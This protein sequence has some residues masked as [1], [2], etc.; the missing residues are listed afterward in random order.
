MRFN[1]YP[2]QIYCTKY[3]N[4]FVILFR[5][6]H[7][8]GYD[9]NTIHLYYLNYVVYLAQ[10]VQIRLRRRFTRKAITKC[11][12]G[13]IICLL[14]YSCRD[15]QLMEEVESN[16]WTQLSN[17]QFSYNICTVL[18]EERH[19][20]FITDVKSSKGILP[21]A[22]TA[23]PN[24]DKLTQQQQCHLPQGNYGSWNN[25]LVT[26]LLPG[27]APKM[28]NKLFTGQTLSAKEEEWIDES[29]HLW[30]SR[31][32]I[33]HLVSM[34]KNCTWIKST[35]KNNFFVSDA[36][37]QF[38][39]AYAINVDRYPHQVLRFL[40]VIY[41]PHNLYCLHFDLKSSHTFKRIIF[42][43]A[44]CLENVIVPRKIEDVYRGWHT[45]IDAH[46]SCFSDLL[47][48]R[49]NYPW[50]Y[51]FTLCGKELPLR[52]NAEIVSLLKPLNGMS[53]VA[54][55]GH[56]GVDPT[57]FHFK[58][59]LST[60][61]GVISMRD[62]RMP[63]TPYGL[64]LYKSWAY[65]A[66]SH[67]FVEHYLCSEVG[68]SLREYMKDA[69]IPEESIYPTLFMKPGVPGG[70]RPEYKHNIFVV[71]SC[72]WR[73][74]ES[75][76]F[77]K[78]YNLFWGIQQFCSGKFVHDVCMI[79]SPDLAMLAFQPG[80][81]GHVVTGGFE[82]AEGKY[83]GPDR[84]PVFHN[85]YLMDQDVVVMDCMEQELV[86]RNQLEYHHECGRR[87]KYREH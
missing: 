46:A 70:F 74:V 8:Y 81:S 5:Y 7:R 42:N 80:V 50:K 9:Q 47:L 86:R 53:S 85:R 49:A 79:T 27:R 61:T 73:N 68:I 66:L 20:R 29:N 43:L 28:C 32:N 75:N 38:P 23:L 1:L 14:V 15:V 41:R 57:R 44:S 31:K 34:T 82:G 76:F 69:Y 72:I 65:I 87:T 55:A 58:W 63:S 21:L 45:L 10:V 77:R 24:P 35:F 59:S 30:R 67:A 71:M 6:K 2:C 26:E 12:I 54:L 78:Y 36:E 60:V 56:N 25:G 84:G 48:A 4:F 3:H 18:M 19:G 33:S 16:P 37:K 22:H 64:K 17:N 83:E 51:I 39:I 40:R 11:C 52:T 62:E 13:V